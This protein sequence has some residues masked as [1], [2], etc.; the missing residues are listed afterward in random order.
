MA[1][2][3]AFA[4]G[5]S[6]EEGASVRSTPARGFAARNSRAAREDFPERD[7]R[8]PPKAFTLYRYLARPAWVMLRTF[9]RSLTRDQDLP[10]VLHD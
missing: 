6:A 2:P 5:T 3:L 8:G 1:V 7:S 9:E 4:R 10:R